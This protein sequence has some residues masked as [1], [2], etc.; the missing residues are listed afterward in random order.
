M[1]A[2]DVFIQ[3]A[4]EQRMRAGHRKRHRGTGRWCLT[5]VILA[6]WEAEIRRI[7]V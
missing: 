4:K 7:V 1:A 3:M 6:I 5:P 2:T